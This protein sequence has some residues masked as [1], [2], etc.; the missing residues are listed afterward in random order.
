LPD[1]LY[2][3]GTWFFT[4]RKKLRVRVF[5][6]RVI[7]RISG[8]KMDEVTGDWRKL[9]NEELN[10]LC[11]SPNIVTM[12][13]SRRKRWARHV[14]RIGRGEG[15]TWC[16]LGN[17]VGKRPLGRPR[18]KCKDNTK[19]DLQE[20]GCG[21]MDWIKLTQDRGKWRALVNEVMNLRVP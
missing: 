17:P 11:C 15:Y 19:M 8:P 16:L 3:C 7:R 13:K 14:A 6:N 5:E 2:G 4:L 20:V 18:R 9:Y 21:G 12:I 10:D 1:V